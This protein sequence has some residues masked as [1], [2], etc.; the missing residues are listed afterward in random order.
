MSRPSLS[1][2]PGQRLFYVL[3]TTAILQPLPA[4]AQS[5]CGP[6]T[7]INFNGTNGQYPAAGVTFDS[8]GNMYGTTAQGGPTFNPIGPGA[9]NL[10]LGTIWKYSPG[11][12]FSS[13]F[14]FSG[15][16]SPSNNGYRPLNALVLDTQGNLYGTTYYGGNDFTPDANNHLGW[17]VLFKYSSAGVFSVLHK[18]SGPDGANPVGLAIDQGNLWGTTWQGGANWNPSL[19]NFGLGTVFEYTSGSGVTNPVLFT[20]ANGGGSIAAGVTPDGQGNYYGTTYE[21][22]T[23]FGTLFKYS[24]TTGQLTTPGKLQPCKWQ[25]AIRHSNPRRPGQYLW[26]DLSGRSPLFAL[27]CRLRDCLE[28]FHQHWHSDDTRQFRW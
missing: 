25:P 28:V 18:F 2:Y 14:A 7:L 15:D 16:S 23:G 4:T 11:A 3:V 12:G 9:L 6:T 5:F 26:H 24:S 19:G 8:L 10:G 27:K 1:C 21:G 13:L 20:G 17:G 22:G